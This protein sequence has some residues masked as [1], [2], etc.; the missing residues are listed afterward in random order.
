MAEIKDPMKTP[1]IWEKA[2][3]EKMKIY[4]NELEEV[5]PYYDPSTPMSRFEILQKSKICIRDLQDQNQDLLNGGFDEVYRSKMAKMKQRVKELLK[6]VDQLTDLLRSANIMIPPLEMYPE[7][8]KNGTSFKWMSQ[9]PKK[10]TEKINLVVP[11]E[12]IKSVLS[13]IKAYKKNSSKIGLKKKGV[14]KN[15]NA[16]EKTPDKSKKVLKKKVKKVTTINQ[17]DEKNDRSNDSFNGSLSPSQFKENQPV[18]Y[19]SLLVNNTIVSKCNSINQTSNNNSTI[20]S[21]DATRNSEQM[22]I[23]NNSVPVQ[24]NHTKVTECSTAQMVPIQSNGNKVGNSQQVVEAQP[25]IVLSSTPSV[26]QS[27]TF[28]LTSEGNLVQLPILNSSGTVFD[29]NSNLLAPATIIKPNAGLLTPIVINKPSPVIVLQKPTPQ[30]IQA[31]QILNATPQVLSVSKPNVQIINSSI[32]YTSPSAVSNVRPL[33]HILSKAPAN[34]KRIMRDTTTTTYV[35]KIPITALSKHS[36]T[37]KGVS[38][39]SA[40]EKSKAVEMKAKDTTAKPAETEVE[41]NENEQE[42]Q[43]ML[44]TT[45]GG[46]GEKESSKTNNANKENYGG[47]EFVMEETGKRNLQED[48]VEANKKQKLKGN[49]EENFFKPIENPM[50][51]DAMFCN[52][53]LPSAINPSLSV[54]PTAA[55]LSSFPIVTP[56]R[57]EV[58]EEVTEKKTDD[59]K[60]SKSSEV[61]RQT[62][63]MPPAKQ[64]PIYT[65]QTENFYGSDHS[66][67]VPAECSVQ[68]TNAN[69]SKVNYPKS[70]F[71]GKEQRCKTAEK[72]TEVKGYPKPVPN[73]YNLFD[74]NEPHVQPDKLAKTVPLYAQQTDNFYL[75][76]QSAKVPSDCSTQFTQSLDKRTEPKCYPKTQTN[77]YNIFDYNYAGTC[78]LEDDSNIQPYPTKNKK[79]VGATKKKTDGLG[80]G[81]SEPQPVDTSKRPPDQILANLDFNSVSNQECFSW[82]PGKN[83]DWL[84]SKSFS[85]DSNLVVPSTL[86]TL[87]GD[88]ALGTNTANDVGLKPHNPK[89]CQS[90]L[91]V[92]SNDIVDLGISSNIGLPKPLETTLDVN[93]QYLEPFANLSK[94]IFDVT[95]SNMQNTQMGKNDFD[96]VGYLGT[97]LGTGSNSNETIVLKNIFELPVAKSTSGTT[98]DFGSRQKQRNITNNQNSFLSVSQLVEPP[99][100]DG[101]GMK[102]EGSHLEAGA[103]VKSDIFGQTCPNFNG[104]QK[105]FNK[106]KS[107]SSHCKYGND[108]KYQGYKN[109]GSSY[110]AEALIRSNNV[111]CQSTA[112]DFGLDVNPNYFNV[113]AGQKADQFPVGSKTDFEIGGKTDFQMSNQNLYTDFNFSSP[114]PNFSIGSSVGAGEFGTH[115]VTGN[116]TAGQ[117]NSYFGDFITPEYPHTDNSL[118]IPPPPPPSCSISL[119]SPFVMDKR[120][121]IEKGKTNSRQYS[122]MSKSRKHYDCTKNSFNQFTLAPSTAIFTTASLTCPTIFTTSACHNL[123]PVPSQSIPISFSSPSFTNSFPHLPPTPTTMTTGNAYHKFPTCSQNSSSESFLPAN[124]M[125]TTSTASKS[126][127][128]SKNGCY[129][130][131]PL[132]SVTNSVISSPFTVGNVPFSTSSQSTLPFFSLS[133]PII[134]SS[135]PTSSSNSL[136]N[137]NLSTIFPEINQKGNYHYS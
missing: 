5:L 54:S 73:S 79:N 4:F 96:R 136:A 56:I 55:F 26:L 72:T 8:M 77:T 17:Q 38:N 89:N 80:Q 128:V 119:Q 71:F 122:A 110:T 65:Q 130:S 126:N 62:G 82:M 40:R 23:N 129:T 94:N 120:N 115:D 85:F 103:S 100:F 43:I 108:R 92:P 76:N 83:V 101:G 50:E 121:F 24:R 78:Y 93:K 68:F 32:I 52:L 88:L 125:F 7:D 109:V 114:V 6:R 42:D 10:W 105:S 31:A 28:I 13:L 12:K 81:H 95:P 102:N 2:R 57:S 21:T 35:N 66:A 123:L 133:N 46:E 75:N 34:K 99:T 29:G 67:K 9:R 127:S 98:A 14:E 15:T 91:K 39:N 19:N 44:K 87:V 20:N 69:P 33:P 53:A 27:N 111:N 18:D 104:S 1:K 41:R 63:K 106:N 70:D 45:E 97:G 59:G 137:F 107:R 113:K 25:N 64:T 11:D 86:P 49:L 51:T 84:P 90:N 3:R 16:L 116:F 74:F 135:A 132:T 58:E 30:I 48:K 134:P 124:A 22:T 47:G 117:N 60:L 61:H 37:K 112:T 131:N 36:Y 118:L